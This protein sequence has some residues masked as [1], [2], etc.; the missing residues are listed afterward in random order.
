MLTE[1]ALAFNG[2]WAAQVDANRVWSGNVKADR[3]F[4]ALLVAE[5]GE[6]LFWAKTEVCESPT[7]ITL[8]LHPLRDPAHIQPIL[9]VRDGY[10][11]ELTVHLRSPDE[12]VRSILPRGGKVGALEGAFV[13]PS[14]PEARL[15][16]L[17]LARDDVKVG[18]SGVWRPRSTTEGLLPPS[19]SVPLNGG[20]EGVITP[21]ASRDAV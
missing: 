13:I 14:D 12:P 8:N 9:I 2:D 18:R 11:Q 21:E 16:L 1:M 4:V 5:S 17:F 3:P 10:L 19:L 6:R 7:A 15:G 20:R